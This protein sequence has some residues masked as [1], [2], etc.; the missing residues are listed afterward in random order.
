MKQEERRQR[1]IKLLLD[2]TKELIEKHGCESIT[3]KQIMDHSGLSKG[4]IFHYVKS[5][6]EI[7][8]WLLE[9]SLAESDNQFQVNVNP[10]EPAFEAPMEAIASGFERLQNPQHAVNRIVMYLLQKSE[11]PEA[12][13]AL[14]RFYQQAVNQAS[15]WIESGQKHGVID[16]DVDKDKTGEWFVVISL[17]L[18]MQS[19]FPGTSGTDAKAQFRKLIESTLKLK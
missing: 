18:R 2:S 9:V 11:L 17:G 8:A 10:A 16:P 6:D 12:R 14:S 4:A 5:K 3:M 19:F 13:E 1:T 15:Q 7:F